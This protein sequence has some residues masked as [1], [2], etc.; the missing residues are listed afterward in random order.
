[1]NTNIVKR[2]K[3]KIKLLA[4]LTA[5]IILLSLTESQAERDCLRLGNSAGQCAKLLD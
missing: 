5:F 2:R 1:M 4:I 3:D